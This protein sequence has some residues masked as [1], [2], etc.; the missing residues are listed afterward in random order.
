VDPRRWIALG[1]V[2]MASFMVLLDISIVNVA[3]PSIQRD[4]NA[5]Y[6]QIQWV[7]AGYQ[8]AYAVILITGGRLGDI[9]G[10]KRLFM[11]GVFGFTS[12]SAL[13]GFA[14]TATWLVI[15]RIL[16]GVLA[17]LMYPQV[18]SVIQISFP[19]R[20]RGAAFGTFGGVIGVATISGPLL[21]GILIKANLFGLDWRPIFLVNVPIGIAALVAA[22]LLLRESRAPSA[23]RLDLPGV[24][25]VTAALFLLTYPLVQGRE[26]GWP[27][28]TFAFLAGA[29]ILLVC[30]ALY[31]VRRAKSVG[32]PLVQPLLFNDRAF[33]TGLLVT[34][35]FLAGVPAFFLTFS[36]YLQIGL[37]FSA[38]DAGLTT[39]PFA[40][41]SAL[42]SA[43]SIRLAPRFG[44]RLLAAG[45]LFL[46]VGMIAIY[47]TIEAAGIDLH[48]YELIPALALSGVGLGCVVAPLITIILAGIHHGD[49][50]SA[51]GVLTTV[52]QVGGAVG[53]AL[54]GIVFF[55]LISTHAD[56]V[57]HSVS[58]SQL[59]PQ[60][61]ALHL[62]EA[63]IS[64][65][66]NGF[67][68]CFHDRS[69]S[70]DPT[71]TPPSCPQSAPPQCNPLPDGPSTVPCIALSTAN[72]AR[73]LDLSYAFQRSL[74]YEL[75][76][77]VASFLLIL[78]LPGRAPPRAHAPA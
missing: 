59:R 70:A 58:Q 53:V 22:T 37:G 78:L 69:T 39:I 23:P 41:A 10:R 31:E 38:L 7:L 76:I 56:D 16:Q 68:Q 14:P 4:L 12:A 1:V 20:E 13:C 51:S 42:A 26:A 36:I 24:T 57:S 65:I 35:L 32:S 9:Y 43:A 64:N 19:P 61:A 30:F 18:L 48:G 40:F 29:A 21:G 2:L 47:A 15:A 34:L 5:S 49:A 46:A 54:I 27:W 73:A 44:K 63:A 62:P 33:V 6:A 74:F 75:G 50:G 52:Q 25:L 55:G 8:L 77:F 17:A 3:I 72:S 45:S 28:W 67:T 11:I 66:T 60:L 71:A